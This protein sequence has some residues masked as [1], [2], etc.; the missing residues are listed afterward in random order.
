MVKEWFISDDSGKKFA[1][2]YPTAIKQ[3][4]EE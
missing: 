1:H 3:E 4:E 2:R